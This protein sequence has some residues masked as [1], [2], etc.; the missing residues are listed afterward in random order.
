MPG[1][2]PRLTLAAARDSIVEHCLT[3]TGTGRV[4]LECEL[5]AF[6]PGD[7]TALADVP[8]P[9]GGRITFEPGGQVEVSGPP[10][11]TVGAAVTAMAHDLT[12]VRRAAAALGVELVAAGF[13]SRP[14]RRLIHSPRYDAMERYFDL[15][16]PA[17]RLMMCN[18]AALQVN[19]DLGPP[20]RWGLVHRIGPVL[21]AAFA[22]SP[23]PA[24]TRSMRL[25]TWWDIDP[26][27]TAPCAVDWADYVL[28]ARVMMIDY[29]PLSTSMTFRRWIEEGHE[30][31]W[32][33]EDDLAYHLT[34]LF[35]PVRARG[36]LELRVID[37]LPDPWWQVAAAVTTALV[38]DEAATGAAT[39]ATSMLS[40][41][42][43]AAADDGL[44]HP[45]LRHAA[46]ACFHAALD[47]L[48]RVGALPA[49]VEA[50]AAY[51]DRYVS[52]GRC[53][54]DDVTA[55]VR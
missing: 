10:F 30:H 23:G 28:D 41:T 11:D 35:P 53:P 54:A 43:Q 55:G 17:G 21:A 34:T 44:S 24:G 6:G 52:R 1:P 26:T 36:W 13:D 49:T 3:P 9:N 7:S 46:C 14:P 37:A 29:R 33:D 4:G 31:G 27:R 40:D 18:T 16:G 42:W 48:P 25:S 47:A 8:L 12:T 22:N 19:L 45:G 39:L 38:E 51:V 2:R 5:L 50:A 20:E 15:D 32:P